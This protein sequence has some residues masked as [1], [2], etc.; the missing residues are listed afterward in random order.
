MRKFQLNDFFCFELDKLKSFFP[1]V[2]I[3]FLFPLDEL[4]NM[5]VYATSLFREGAHERGGRAHQKLNNFRNQF[6]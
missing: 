6:K 3:T 5:C 2:T 4:F 1:L